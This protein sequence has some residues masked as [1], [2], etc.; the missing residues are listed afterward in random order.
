MLKSGVT[1][2]QARRLLHDAR[3]NVRRAIAIKDKS[4]KGSQK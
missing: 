1:V 2:G 4:P 3:G